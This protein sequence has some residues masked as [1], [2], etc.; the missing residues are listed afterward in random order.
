[1]KKSTN[2]PFQERVLPC[3]KK[4]L[5]SNCDLWILDRFGSIR[6]AGNYVRL[7]RYLKTEFGKVKEEHY[8]HHLIVGR[9]SG[10][11]ID[12]INRNPL[13][14]RRENLRYATHGQNVV[15]SGPRKTSKSGLKGVQYHPSGGLNKPWRAYLVYKRDGKKYQQFLKRYTTKKEAA[16]AYNEMAKKIHGEFAF[17]NDLSKLK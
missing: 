9:K 1:M 11:E 8:L 7:C 10:Y 3:G 16:V 2:K 15:N 4:F 6:W 14:N 13:D 12:H 17:Q 5:I